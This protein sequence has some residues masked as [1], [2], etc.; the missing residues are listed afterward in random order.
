MCQTGG[1]KVLH[2]SKLPKYPR[3]RHS[4]GNNLYVIISRPGV[5]SFMYRSNKYRE[6]LGSIDVVTLAEAR[7]KAAAIRKLE[8]EGKDP[9]AERENARLDQEIAK[10]LAKSFRE[11]A[12]K[13]FETKLAGRY[14]ST[15]KGLQQILRVHILP[16]IGDMPIGKIT[17]NVILSDTGMGLE[18][19]WLKMNPT[20]NRARGLVERILNFAEYRGYPVHLHKGKNAAAWKGHLEHLLPAPKEVHTGKHFASLP[21]QDAPRFVAALR[22]YKCRSLNPNMHTSMPLLAEFF[23]FT[24]VRENEGLLMAWGQIDATRKVITIPTGRDGHVKRKDEREVPREIPIT[25][26]ILGLLERARKKCIFEGIDPSNPNAPVFPGM[27]GAPHVRQSC[28]EFLRSALNWEGKITVHGLRS[29]LRDWCRANGYPGEW[30]EIQVDHKL[31][32]ATSQAY[33]HDPLLEQ[34]R[35]M[36]EAWGEFCTRPTPA[37][38]TNVA[39]INEARKKRRAA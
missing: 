1:R 16:K 27:R 32:N 36:M 29:T 7:A 20:A 11:V 3:G 19:K 15:I 4:D 8:H 2:Q 33:G 26:A 23:L 37:A 14:P 24:G 18:K 13:F 5:G 35:K 39:Q 21:Y 12:E 38:G 6:G 25:T 10:G 22:G 30:W 31:G 34:R 17:A 9:K 28:C